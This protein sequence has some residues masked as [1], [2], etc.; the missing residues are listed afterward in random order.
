MVGVVTIIRQ[1]PPLH[2]LKTVLS[3]SITLLT[4]VVT[5]STDCRVHHAHVSPDV[6]GG[7]E[8]L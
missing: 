8:V 5:I 3:I 7:H 1:C 2:H 4:R 6:S